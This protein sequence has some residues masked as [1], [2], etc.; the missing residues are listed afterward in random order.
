LAGSAEPPDLILLE[1]M[2]PGLDGFEVCRP[3]NTDPRTRGF[4]ILFLTATRDAQEEDGEC[5]E[6]PIEFLEEGYVLVGSVETAG[7]QVLLRNGTIPTTGHLKK[8]NYDSLIGVISGS[9]SV[10]VGA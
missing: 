9:I 8:L 10:R 2:M 5:R 1:V 4:S 3:L 6:V 7:G